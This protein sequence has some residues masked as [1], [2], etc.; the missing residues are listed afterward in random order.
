MSSPARQAGVAEVQ[1]GVGWFRA[2]MMLVL[3]AAIMMRFTRSGALMHDSR[4]LHHI[5]A[6]SY[7]LG[8]L[9]LL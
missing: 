3:A 1:G 4:A 6:T 8:I 9:D 7:I 2:K 5:S